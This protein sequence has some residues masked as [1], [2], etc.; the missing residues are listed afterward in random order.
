MKKKSQLTVYF[1]IGLV[2][3]F[4]VFTIFFLQKKP[5][6][7]NNQVSFENKLPLNLKNCLETN[8]YQSIEYYGLDKE[9]NYNYLYKKADFCVKSIIKDFEDK[10]YN[11]ER[12]VPILYIEINEDSFIINYTNNIKIFKGKESYSFDSLNLKIPLKTFLKTTNKESILFSVD[13]QAKLYIPEDNNINSVLSVKNINKNFDNLKN[14]IVVSNVY[15]FEPDG[16]TFEKPLKLE[17]ELPKTKFFDYREATIAYFDKKAKIWKGLKTEM[18]DNKLVTNVNHFTKFAIVIGCN[19]ENNNNVIN[20]PLL[21]QQKYGYNFKIKDNEREEDFIKRVSE[22][23]NK[24]CLEDTDLSKVIWKENSDKTI[25]PN[26]EEYLKAKNLNDEER[27]IL[28]LQTLEQE[29]YSFD[30]TSECEN[31]V[32]VNLYCCCNSKDNGLN[33][34]KDSCEILTEQECWNKNYYTFDYKLVKECP[35]DSSLYTTK[36]EKLE[37]GYNERKC[38]GGKIEDGN[39]DGNVVEITFNKEGNAC[40]FEEKDVEVIPIYNNIEN[41]DKCKIDYKV[42]TENG[43][44]ILLK[45][46]NVESPEKSFCAKC[47]ADIKFNGIGIEKYSIKKECNENEKYNYVI[48]NYQVKCKKCINGFTSDELLTEEEQNECESQMENKFR[49]NK[50]LVGT[51]YCDIMKICDEN[52]NLV[53]WEDEK[54]ICNDCALLENQDLEKCEI[55][56]YQDSEGELV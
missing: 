12:S 10:G 45:S 56:V 37:Y 40:I 7:V 33:P 50:Y 15:E 54:N 18:V 4:L 24:F 52:L 31:E 19:S 30:G 34:E 51:A 28:N 38:L 14:D 17:I 35:Q 26:R 53:D 48:E 42:D 49:C 8:A 32:E 3:I 23:S 46:I 39:N 27:I 9:K 55:V 13:K 6:L 11:I 5:Y 22:I 47:S 2:F 29:K 20:L 41:S 36:K 25:T 1:I 21:F 16:L 44:R 43:F